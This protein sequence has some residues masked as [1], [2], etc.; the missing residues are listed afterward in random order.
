MTTYWCKRR[1]TRLALAGW[2]FSEV[3]QS[4]AVKTDK[5][6]PAPMKLNP[7]HVVSK[8]AAACV[9]SP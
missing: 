9:F 5:C 7:L 1:G 3:S 8:L 4:S 2:S 6:Y